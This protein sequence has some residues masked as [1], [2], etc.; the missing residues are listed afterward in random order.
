[1]GV[2]KLKYG[3]FLF[4]IILLVGCSHPDA[5]TDNN[6]AT[7]PQVTVIN[8]AP[9]DSEEV[10][11]PD[12]TTQLI[13]NITTTENNLPPSTNTKQSNPD[14]PEPED[15]ILLDG[16]TFI[17]IM[18]NPKFSHRI[19]VAQ[20]YGATLYAIENSDVFAIVKDNEILVSMS[21][22][23]TAATPVH[24]DILSDVLSDQGEYANEI[25]EGINHVAST[26]ENI[27]VGPENLGYS[28]FKQ[29]EWIV[30]SW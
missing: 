8:E 27:H 23:I 26:G 6:E 3:L 17:K 30:V 25:R 10:V 16:E 9:V 24:K 18:D 29:E 13:D 19:S 15:S 20:K 28:I 1:M 12:N 2:G 14:N 7:Q 21:T 22:G 5:N 4:M 11:L